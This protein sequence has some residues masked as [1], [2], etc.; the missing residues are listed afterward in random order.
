PWPEIIR[1]SVDKYVACSGTKLDIRVG[2]PGGGDE[3]IMR[4]VER[5]SCPDSR[6]GRQAFRISEW[7]ESLDD[8][9]YAGMVRRAR[10]FIAAGDIY[11]V[12]L[13]RWFEADFE[14]DAWGLFAEL[15]RRNPSPYSAYIELPGVDGFAP[16]AIVSASPELLFRIE[17]FRIVTRPIAGTY[18]REEAPENLP[19]DPKERAE[20]IMLIDLE[21][22][23]LGRIGVPG[24]VKV[25]ELLTVETY[26][27]LHHIVSQVAA[28]LRPGTKLSQVMRAV[29][30][31]GTITGCPKVRAMEI[32]DELETFRR[33]LY[34][35]S[36]GMLGSEGD[37]VFNIAIRTAIVRDGKIRLAAGA[38]IV[39]DSD[40]MREA[41]ETRV[42]AG[43]FLDARSR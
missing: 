8:E 15:S 25:E 33:G 35:G 43:A 28:E 19:R 39:A 17:G 38:G 36:I 24:S 4:A 6:A 40:P 14:G 27:H 37:A 32:I 3:E 7:K 23:D 30:P 20:H 22:N 13:A 16:A 29:F 10:E 11:Q 31:G 9:H 41:H 5:A 34:T 26:S 18:P 12:N 21:R 1:I 42:K 2:G